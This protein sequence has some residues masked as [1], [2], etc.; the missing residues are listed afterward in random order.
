VRSESK[1][2]PAFRSALLDVVTEV[3]SAG[4]LLEERLVSVREFHAGVAPVETQTTPVIA[5]NTRKSGNGFVVWSS[6]NEG[7]GW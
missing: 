6:V 1:V 3:P 4:Q 5:A 7:L 2:S